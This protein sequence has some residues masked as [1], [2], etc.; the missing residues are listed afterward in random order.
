MSMLLIFS[1][2]FFRIDAPYVAVG[3]PETILS[4]LQVI[5][6]ML[7]FLCD[8]WQAWINGQFIGQ[9]VM[10]ACWDI[11]NISKQKYIYFF[12]YLKLYMP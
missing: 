4:R 3:Y 10:Q 5:L 7:Q 8:M 2:I 9:I 11:A 1:L 6:T 12:F